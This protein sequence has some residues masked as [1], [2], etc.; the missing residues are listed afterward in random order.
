M[1]FIEDKHLRNMGL[2]LS[3][4]L[5]LVVILFVIIATNMALQSKPDNK[6]QTDT[7]VSVF[8]YKKKTYGFSIGPKLLI[9]NFYL[10]C[11]GHM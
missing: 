5:F 7:H 11:L 8:F 6:Q 10:Y 2:L 1:I 3:V 4:V 9:N